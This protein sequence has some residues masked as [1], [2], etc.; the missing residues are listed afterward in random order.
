M[1]LG[2]WRAVTGG[3]A[4]GE[5]GPGLA[6]R[7]WPTIQWAEPERFPAEAM[8]GATGW[9]LAGGVAS[10]MILGGWGQGSVWAE[11]QAGRGFSDDPSRGA[12]PGLSGNRIC[13][14]GRT[15][16]G[17]GRESSLGPGSWVRGRGRGV[18]P[19]SFGLESA[20]GAWGV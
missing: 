14:P 11:R 19:W 6:E 9:R 7:G 16:G 4:S 2:R 13:A 17:V 18:D 8:G 10:A 5:A 1:G 12:G 20:R 3:V 15:P